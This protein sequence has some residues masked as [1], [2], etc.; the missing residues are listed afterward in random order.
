[1]HRPPYSLFSTICFLDSEENGN[2]GDML[3]RL[4]AE[5]GGGQGQDGQKGEFPQKTEVKPGQIPADPHHDHQ[6]EYIKCV[7][8]PG[9][10]G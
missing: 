3:D 2:P 1:M 9:K 4:A 10:I 8:T 6:V 5:Q 7:G